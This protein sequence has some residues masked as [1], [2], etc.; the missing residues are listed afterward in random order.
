MHT[1]NKTSQCICLWCLKPLYHA[2]T[3][4]DLFVPLAMLCHDCSS[5]IPKKQH[6]YTIDTLKCESMV[7][8]DQDIER[9]LFR[10][11]E[12]GDLPMAD[13][14]FYHARDY[15][16]KHKDYVFVLMPSSTQKTKERGFFTLEKMVSS[17]INNYQ[18]PLAKTRNIKQ[19][20]QSAI[21]RKEISKSM[22]LTSIQG[23]KN[24]KIIL[25]DDVCT[26]GSTLLSA[27]FLVAP[28]AQSVKAFTFAASSIVIGKG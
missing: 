19:S 3:L 24:K 20:E 15:F 14:F 22:T 27:Y 12:D 25:I 16:K 9:I 2:A 18:T 8:Y 26:T 21:N 1:K 17:Y 5:K 6:T 4:F 23:I 13:S 7:V 10:Y 28:H 11:K